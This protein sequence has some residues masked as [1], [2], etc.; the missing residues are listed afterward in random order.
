VVDAVSYDGFGQVT[1]ETNASAGDA[2]KYNGGRYD[3]LTGFTL[4][5][6]REYD[7][8]TGSWTTRDPSGFGG[9]DYNIY[10]YVGN[11]PTNGTDPS[12]LQAKAWY[13]NGSDF[14]NWVGDVTGFNWIINDIAA[15][16]TSVLEGFVPVY[17]PYRSA[18]RDF[19]GLQGNIGSPNYEI[20]DDGLCNPWGYVN[21]GI[22]I[23]DVVGLGLATTPGR[24]GA[25]GGGFPRGSQAESLAKSGNLAAAGRA[26]AK[27]MSWGVRGD[28]VSL[29]GIT[30][31]FR[32]NPPAP[33]GVPPTPT[34]TIPHPGNIPSN[35][36][37]GPGFVWHGQPP[38][39]GR[40]GNWFNSATGE[41]LSN[42]MANL[43]H[44]P[45]WDYRI[46]GV[47]GKWRWYPDGRL[48][49]TK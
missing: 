4:F 34:P 42:D 35:Q 1:A 20:R 44:G 25:P 7:A 24:G 30:G 32:M 36:A 2:Y 46:Q 13:E 22:A 33:G 29:G 37:P 10:R 21:L 43:A 8:A 12:G 49:Y 48:E 41:S 11:S 40:Q 18:I 23:L 14:D 28:W 3:S 17:G 9:G 38:A 31:L 27:N 45:H 39:G 16:E 26:N 15:R 19:A 6:A 47:R 5:G